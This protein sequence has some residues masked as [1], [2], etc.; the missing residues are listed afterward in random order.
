METAYIILLPTA[1]RNILETSFA[2]QTGGALVRRLELR[3]GQAELQ[4]DEESTQTENG[5]KSPQQQGDANAVG[6][7]EHHRRCDIDARAFMGSQPPWIRHVDLI[8]TDG[9]IQYQ[10]HDGDGAQFLGVGGRADQKLSR[11]GCFCFCLSLIYPPLV[12]FSERHDEVLGVWDL[13]M[14]AR[15]AAVLDLYPI[16]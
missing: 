4:P 9:A 13:W 6:G 15:R 11:T 10:A 1:P 5:A 7:S 12:G 3:Y 2:L 16:P 8:H 14:R